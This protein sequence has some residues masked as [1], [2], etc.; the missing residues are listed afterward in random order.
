MPN[1]A[2]SAVYNIRKNF[3]KCFSHASLCCFTVIVGH[4]TWSIARNQTTSARKKI[5]YFNIKI[6]TQK[7][8][9]FAAWF[10]DKRQNKRADMLNVSR[11]FVA[12]VY[13]NISAPDT[14]PVGSKKKDPSAARRNFVAQWFLLKLSG[15]A[16]CCLLLEI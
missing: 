12:L 10:Q 1:F 9:N 16:L 4:A 3:W 14:F 13:F 5:Y 2:N 6:S 8:K 7:K 11:H 15:D